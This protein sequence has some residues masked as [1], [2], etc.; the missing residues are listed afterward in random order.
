[1]PSEYE[2]RRLRNL[3]D[4]KRV[5]KELGLWNDPVIFYFSPTLQS[6]CFPASRHRGKCLR[7]LLKTLLTASVMLSYC[8]LN[9]YMV[10]PMS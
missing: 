2:E 3:E 4:N 9:P 6:T 5:L 10:S 8:D 7:G 1:M